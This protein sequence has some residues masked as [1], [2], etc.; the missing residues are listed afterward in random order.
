VAIPIDTRNSIFVL[1]GLLVVLPI[2]YI[3]D[4]VTPDFGQNIDLVYFA[5]F[6]RLLVGFSIGG[7]IARSSFTGPAV[8]L[9][10]GAWIYIIAS[11]FGFAA[12]E[13][14][15]LVDIVTGNLVGLAIFVVAAAAGAQIGMRSRTRLDSTRRTA[16]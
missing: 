14:D 1:S 8:V 4:F 13:F 5:A 11:I 9:G 7:L 12:P 2:T 16:T 15:Q 3:L 10:I 6:V